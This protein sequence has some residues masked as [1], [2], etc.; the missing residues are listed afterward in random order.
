MAAMA[1]YPRHDP[2]PKERPLSGQTVREG[3]MTVSSPQRTHTPQ[4][5]QQAG[6]WGMLV[7]LSA[8]LTAGMLWA[9]VPA[10]LFLGPMIAAIVLAISGG[11]IR[12]PRLVYGYAQALVGL[13][14]AHNIP[15]GVLSETLRNGPVF[16][17]GIGLVIIVSYSAGWVLARLRILPGTTALWGTSPGAATAMIVMAADFGADTRLVAFMQSLRMVCV[18]LAATS[19]ATIWS[20]A[21]VHAAISWTTPV[22]GSAIAATL[23][24]ATAA[25]V[26]GRFVRIPAAA[27]LLPLVGGIALHGI[28]PLEQPPWLSASAYAVIGWGVGLVF[29]RAALRNAFAALPWILIAIAAMIGACGVVGG[30]LVWL[31]GVDPLTAYLAT[32]P[33]GMDTAAIIAASCKADLAFVMSMQAARFVL[34]L[35]IGPALSKFLATRLPSEPDDGQIANP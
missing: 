31:A 1:D 12:L 28:V 4:R 29:T 18:A 6:R 5:R 23:A 8:L 24:L 27:F 21:P 14:I 30:L 3:T 9:H 16:L 25:V 19:V 20:H 10:A 17:L 33:G 11:G 32:S 7:V 34:V 35:A 26:A 13:V 2:G 15:S 22:A